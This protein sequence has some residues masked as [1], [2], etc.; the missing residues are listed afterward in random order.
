[1]SHLESLE[2]SITIGCS[3]PV[4][5][6]DIEGFKSKL[7]P[8]KEKSLTNTDPKNPKYAMPDQYGALTT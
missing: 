5:D 7:M 3:D 2:R 6:T 1:M 4:T 8:F